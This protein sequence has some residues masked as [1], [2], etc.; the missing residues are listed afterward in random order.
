M[1][2][3]RVDASTDNGSVHINLIGEIDLANASTVEEQIHAAVSGQP[4][5]VSVDL[6]ELT[7]MD[8]VGIKLL[9]ELASNL[10][11]SNITL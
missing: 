11:E 5:A 1:T 6:T 10:Q 8:S 9:F 7:Y 2:V 3:A 4:T